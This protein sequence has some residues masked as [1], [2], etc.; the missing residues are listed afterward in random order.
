MPLLPIKADAYARIEAMF[1]C[2]HDRRELRL[3]TI[4]GGRP[5]YYR[6]CTMCGNAG[7]AISAREANAVLEATNVTHVF[8]NDL[9]A[10]WLA[11]KH[12]AYVLTY[13]EIAPAMGR[14]Y[15]AY[16]ASQEWSRRRSAALLRAKEICEVC[17]HFQAT[18]A[19]HVTYARVGCELPDDLLAVCSFCHG[20]LHG[21]HAL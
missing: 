1:R 3:R 4:A 2:S 15:D 10:M 17:K 8:D 16:L 14:E 21:R 13:Q 20:L 12:S 6:Q 11:R 19:H 7:P 9:E 18:E 5:A